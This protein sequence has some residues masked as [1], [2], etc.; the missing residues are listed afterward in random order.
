MKTNVISIQSY[1]AYGYVG[2]KCACPIFFMNDIPAD[3]INTVQ[4]MEVII[5]ISNI[6]TLDWLIYVIN[7]FW[8][9]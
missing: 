6:I 4:R 3:F 5:Y 9:Y 1:V 2:N 7:F 8:Y